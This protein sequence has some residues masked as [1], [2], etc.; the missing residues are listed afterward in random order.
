M[1]EEENQEGDKSQ[2][3]EEPTAHKLEKARE[4]GQ[5]PYSRDLASFLSLL[6]AAILLRWLGPLLAHHVV[7]ILA[8]YVRVSDALFYGDVMGVLGSLV[9]QIC[10]YILLPVALLGVVAVFSVLIQKGLIFAPSVL[11]PKLARISIFEGIK[12]IFSL[13]G[14]VE[15]I[16]G[17]LKI[18]LIATCLYFALHPFIKIISNASDFD[19]AQIVHLLFTLVNKMLFVTCFIV[20]LLGILDFFYQRYQYIAGM[21]MSRYEI[22]EEHKH[23]EGDPMVKSK[24]RSIAIKRAKTRMMSL[25]PK[26]DVVIVNPV[27]Y[28]VALHYDIETMQAPLVVAK[29]QDYIALAIKEI[30]KEYNI[31]IVENPLLAK[32]LFFSTDVESFI[33]QEHYE[34]VA[35]IISY[36]MKL[37]MRK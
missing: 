5:A 34:A 19:T 26:A 21:K 27:H 4:E 32:L 6:T 20:A 18:V 23:H 11:K 28:A 7:D 10:P 17:L 31:P 29:G 13:N 37:Q 8:R 1:S 12:R 3:T 9:W 25:V 14:L 35:A 33:P 2:K 24:L 36:V 16:K 30:A 15:T 22:K